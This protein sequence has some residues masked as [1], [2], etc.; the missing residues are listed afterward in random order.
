M[1]DR[2]PT[3]SFSLRHL[4]AAAL[5]ASLA[6]GACAQASLDTSPEIQ[7]AMKGLASEDP[8][9]Q[10]ARWGDL[11]AAAGKPW[12]H[13]APG[14]VAN[15]W[16][17]PRWV[18]PG[19]VMRYHRGFCFAA[20]CQGTD[21]LVQYNAQAKQLEF[22]ENGSVAYLGRIQEDGS[23]RLVGTGLVGV[24]TAET[25]KFDAAAGMLLSDKHELKPSSV[26]QL[27]AATRGL[28]G[29]E[30]TVAT[31]SPPTGSDAQ[32]RA[33]LEAMKAKVEA[34]SRQ[35]EQQGSGSAQAASAPAPRLTAK[36]AREAELRAQ[37][38]AKARAAE[39]ARLAREEKTREEAARRAEVQE[40]ARAEAQAKAA[41]AQRQAEEKRERQEAARRAAEEA[42]AAKA[43]E[44]QR[45]REEVARRAEAEA[46]A[47]KTT[48]AP[49][50]AK[51]NACGGI[52]GIYGIVAGNYR[53]EV[54]FGDEMLM[55]REPNR[56]SPYRH[57]GQCQYAFT[58]PNGT[59][60]RLGV[61]ARALVAYK[62][63]QT[64]AQKTELALIQA[65][66]AP[67]EKG[68]CKAEE[69]PVLNPEALHPGF[70][71]LFGTR[72]LQGVELAGTYKA[73]EPDGHPFTELTAGGGGTFEV[74]GAPKPQHVYRISSWHIQVNCDGTPL[75]EHYPAGSRYFLVYKVQ[76]AY[77]GQEWHRTQYIVRKDRLSIDD[78]SKQR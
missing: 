37:R 59:E 63:G 74:Y 33:E 24:L 17:Y 28:A 8:A 16:R 35:V 48:A 49:A 21:Y 68:K 15:V 31:A 40:R 5:L 61:R 12:L 66:A 60:Y 23:V 78:R 9:V 14:E 27:A 19:A 46:K 72:T 54:K 69:I 11:A 20:Q 32:L 62:P 71:R 6:S 25:L 45:A 50:A 76:P 39:E 51:P 36:Q 53:I 55:V 13:V 10:R 3:P 58:H 52:D 43:A 4:A 64:D 65:A 67:Q 7:A 73:P 18:V 75:V 1:T 30:T 41:E 2:Q 77:Q 38:E 70:T 44:V 47:V 26:A 29:T 34:L 22:L 42:K 57:I 56:E